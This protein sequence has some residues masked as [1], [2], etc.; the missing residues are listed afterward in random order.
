MEAT[1]IRTCQAG[2]LPSPDVD[3]DI[4]DLVDDSDDEDDKP[5]V[6]EDTLEDGDRIFAATIP[7]E[8][9]FIW[10]TSNMLQ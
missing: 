8:M 2:P 10:A 7:C 6:G 9:E 3:M 4:P 5:Y 1:S